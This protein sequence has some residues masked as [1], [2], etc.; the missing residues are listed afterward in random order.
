MIPQE[1]SS[2]DMCYLCHDGG[3]LIICDYRGCGKVYHTQC[4]NI[5]HTPEGEWN[6]ARHYCFKC[7]AFVGTMG[8]ACSRCVINLCDACAPVLPPST[9]A[10]TAA[11]ASD[12]AA[13]ATALCMYCQFNEN[14]TKDI[15][16]HIIRCSSVENS[17]AT[18]TTTAA[19]ASASASGA[20]F[21]NRSGTTN[22]ALS[23]VLFTR[24]CE[25]LDLLA[26]LV[27]ISFT[28][29]EMSA[30]LNRGAD[31]VARALHYLYHLQQQHQPAH[32]PTLCDT[33]GTDSTARLQLSSHGTTSG[34][35]Q[36][37]NA[38]WDAIHNSLRHS[39]LSS[40]LD[41]MLQEMRM[42]L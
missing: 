17:T 3:K 5:Q 33:G 24:Q 34:R 22:V 26:S 4:V 14:P 6:C 2:D 37:T 41:L 35:P 42:V 20:G 38:L 21:R 39:F 7:T 11:P 15:R 13:G 18:A 9:A 8:R 29:P 28:D 25:Q 30:A 27:H 31:T 1:D 16:K 23:S 40:E 19:S 10:A 32:F 12:P 36:T